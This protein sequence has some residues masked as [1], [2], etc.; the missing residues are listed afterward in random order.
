MPADVKHDSTVILTE[1]VIEVVYPL[2]RHQYS[3]QTVDGAIELADSIILLLRPHQVL[4]IP[5]DSLSADDLNDLWSF[6]N[7][8][9]LLRQA[10]GPDGNGT[11][12][13]SA[14]RIIGDEPFMALCAEILPQR[15]RSGHRP[16]D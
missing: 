10:K 4:P 12:I 5:R 2:R 14:A 11:P 3:W 15:R 16:A 8:R 9:G 6:R 13:L 7:R 1:D